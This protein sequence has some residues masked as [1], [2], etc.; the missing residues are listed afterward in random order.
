MISTVSSSAGSP[1][2]GE[3]VGDLVDQV[4]VE[5]LAGRDVDVDLVRAPGPVLAPRGGCGAG[6]LQHPPADQLDQ[7]GLLGQRDEHQRRDEAAL[8]VPFHRS[9]A[10]AP[11]MAPAREV[12]DGLVVQGELL[13]AERA[14]QVVLHGRPVQQPLAHR[15]DEDLDPG[16]AG[17]FGRV[18]RHVG[19]LEHAAASRRDRPSSSL[20]VAM[21]TLAW[22]NSGV[23]R[24][25]GS[26]GAARGGDAGCDRLRGRRCHAA[27]E[28]HG[29]LVTAEPGGDVG[30]PDAG[31]QPVGHLPQQVVPRT[32]G[33]WC[34]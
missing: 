7:P 1:V 34:R 21:P 6:V 4:G 28:Q 15:G 23:P 19:L 26:A 2:R 16:L 29:E 12:D 8:R 24:R 32:R 14:G 22:M 30:A 27:G 31:L 3:D 10:S 33:P 18:H 20:P 13:P 5:Q 17:V 25:R 11:T 9:S